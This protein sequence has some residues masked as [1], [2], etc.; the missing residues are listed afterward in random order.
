MV[1]ADVEQ[2]KRSQPPD[3]EAQLPGDPQLPGTVQSTFSTPVTGVDDD[4]GIVS[5]RLSWDE[6]MELLE[7]EQNRSPVDTM[8]NRPKGEKL[9]LTKV[10]K[11]TEDFLREAFTTLDNEDRKSIRKR[12]IV[13]DTPFTMAPHLDKVMAAECSKSTKAADQA[14][15]R[16]QALF[17][18]AVGPLTELLDGINKGQELAID[19]VE[20]AVKA[21]LNLMGSASSH[22][23]ALRRTSVLEEYNKDLVAFSQGPDL[24]NSATTTLF[25][26]SFPEKAVEQLKQL[27]TLR[28]ARSAPKS[29]TSQGFS[30]APSQYTQRGGRAGY[31]RRCQNSYP[32]SRGGYNNS[33]GRGATSSQRTK[34]K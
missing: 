14:H 13:P 33:R 16:I 3:R 29:G 34:G 23:T 27:H 8:G 15:S 5:T 28:Q 12:F 17:L 7:D 32:Y 1:C 19:D 31:L 10:E 26:P 20:V 22:C 25:G 18:D 24:F 4:D 9:P 2:L 11:E 21:A 30:K 6:Q